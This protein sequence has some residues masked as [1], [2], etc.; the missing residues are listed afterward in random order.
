MCFIAKKA[1]ILEL[2][3]S[4]TGLVEVPSYDGTI[5]YHGSTPRTPR[6]TQALPYTRPNDK[7]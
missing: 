7:G 2:I 4:A 6:M 5:H 1:S 3:D